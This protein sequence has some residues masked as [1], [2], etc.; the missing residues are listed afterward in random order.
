MCRCSPKY[1][2]LSICGRMIRVTCSKTR[3]IAP[4]VATIRRPG[5]CNRQKGRGLEPA[6]QLFSKAAHF[7]GIAPR[8]VASKERLVTHLKS[9]DLVVPAALERG[10]VHP[11]V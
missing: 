1:L 4:D 10:K 6:A 8:L 11:A 2:V 7:Q 5:K 3:E 9:C